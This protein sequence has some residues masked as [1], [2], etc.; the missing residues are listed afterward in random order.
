MT[1]LHANSLPRIRDGLLSHHLEDQVLVYDATSDRVHLL[2]RTTGLVYQLLEESQRNEHGITAELA[3][4]SGCESSAEL[5]ELSV[6]ELRRAGLLDDNETP[7]RP[8]TDVTRREMLRRL[9]IAGVAAMLIPAIATLTA[10]KAYGQAS[11]LPQCAPCTSDAQCCTHCDA[12]IHT[13]CG[14]AKDI[15]P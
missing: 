14:L 4:L 13:R 5:F 11:C 8:L 12:N 3:R 6:D 9:G 2:D 7:N 1:E 15:C 10:D